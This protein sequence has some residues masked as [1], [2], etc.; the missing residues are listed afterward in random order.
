[1]KISTS[2]WVIIFFLIGL[3]CGPPAAQTKTE[4]VK[5]LTMQ[6]LA[7]LLPR[8][9]VFSVPL[10]EKS[11]NLT[12]V[13]SDVDVPSDRVP[14]PIVY[15]P[16]YGLYLVNPGPPEVLEPTLERFASGARRLYKTSLRKKLE[17]DKPVAY[18]PHDLFIGFHGKA[19]LLSSL[20]YNPVRDK[21]EDFILAFFDSGGNLVGVTNLSQLKDGYPKYRSQDGHLW[22]YTRE[23]ITSYWAIYSPGGELENRIMTNSPGVLL[24]NGKL[25]VLTGETDAVLYDS[26]GKKGIAKVRGKINLG[27][28]IIRGTGF[29]F[30]VLSTPDPAWQENSEGNLQQPMTIQV[31]CFDPQSCTLIV[32][33]DQQLPPNIFDS[34]EIPRHFE[35][36]D[37]NIMSFDDEG[38]LYIIGRYGPRAPHIRVYRMSMNPD[39]RESILE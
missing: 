7:I 14:R 29:F 4:V 18:L 1:M 25:L 20:T 3:A 22:V 13:M 5:K 27:N 24:P 16:P 35:F 33:K 9:E 15:Y 34:N 11:F 36:Y 12:Y 2:R 32:L 17:L 30:G 31:I 38:N 6:Q 21:N 10:G 19:A 28:P 26:K 8:A 37:P 23:R 39:V